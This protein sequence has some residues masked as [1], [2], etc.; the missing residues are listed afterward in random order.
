MILA[1]AGW[2]V[3]S[4]EALVAAEV[5]PNI[6]L[7]PSWCPS[8]IVRKMVDQVGAERVLFGS[9]HLGSVWVLCMQADALYALYGSEPYRRCYP[10]S[11][12]RVCHKTAQG[13]VQ[14]HR[15]G[16]IEM[17]TRHFPSS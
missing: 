3:Y 16:R 17:L 10:Y 6:Y 7:E 15:S 8:Y 4:A 9:D 1:H 13:R 12:P 5:C 2:G 14:L 11:A